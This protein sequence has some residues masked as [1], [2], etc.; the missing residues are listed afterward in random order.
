MQINRGAE[1]GVLLTL[2]AMSAMLLPA[3]AFT[4]LH[5][6][7][8]LSGCADGGSPTVPLIQG[9][10]GNLYGTTGTTVFMT[11]PAGALNTLYTFACTGNKCP[12]GK[13]PYALVQAANGEFYGTA[14]VGGTKNNGTVFKLTA[15]GTLTTLHK[16]AGS[17]GSDPSAALLLAGN[18]DFYGITFSG[19][20]NSGGTA[21]RLSPGG[22]LTTLF[23]FCST[24]ACQAG[25]GPQ[26]IIQG[27]N[28][29][30]YGTAWE[31][32]VDNSGTLFKMT[33]A[34]V[35]TTLHAFC[36]V[37]NCADGTRPDGALVQAADE[38][39]YGT[40]NWGGANCLPNG[41]GVIYKITPAGA[42]TTLYNFCSETNCADGGTPTRG[43]LRGVTGTSTGPPTPVAPTTP[44]PSSK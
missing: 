12:D 31:T 29:D 35:A 28:G 40:T 22:K 13:Y 27:T 39:F 23:N 44:V 24:F 30:F 26:S 5:T 14:A 41:C 21:F 17:D 16:F 42:L 11:T 37:T 10:D 20:A 6:F 2:C 18:G 34:G 43:S 9:N 15:G 32:P 4:L 19:G 3:Q 8:S 36:S 25:S 7:C 1:A 38:S 33:P